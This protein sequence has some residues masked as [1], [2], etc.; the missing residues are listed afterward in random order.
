MWPN[1]LDFLLFIVCWIFH[2]SMTPYS[3]SFPTWSVQ[4]ISILLHHDI[5]KV[6]RHLW[7]TFQVSKFQHHIKLCTKHT[8][9]LVSSLQLSPI[10]WWKQSSS[11]WMLLLPWAILNFICLQLTSLLSCYPKKFKYSIFCGCFLS[12]VLCNRDGCLEIH[13]TLV[14][15]TII[16][17]P[18]HLIISISLWIMSCST[19]SSSDSSTRSSAY[20]TIQIT[21]P[22]L[23]KSPNPSMASLVRYLL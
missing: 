7:S 21:C 14:F 11:C 6:S 15:S 9:S 4:L 23:L 16:P 2:F 19:T 1:Q 3:T 18:Y 17:I 12:I 13:I 20:Y 8:I 5:S 22:P 10:C